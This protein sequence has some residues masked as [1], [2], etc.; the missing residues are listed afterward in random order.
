[1]VILHHNKGVVKAVYDFHP[2]YIL[3]SFQR[4][5]YSILSSAPETHFVLLDGIFLGFYGQI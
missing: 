3:I 1:M 4:C 5:I 2:I